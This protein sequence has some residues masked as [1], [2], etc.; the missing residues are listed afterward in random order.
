MK[1]ATWRVALLRRATH[2]VRASR[3]SREDGMPSENA[4]GSLEYG[5]APHDEISAGWSDS[6]CASW[7]RKRFKEHPLMAATPSRVAGDRNKLRVAATTLKAVERM[8][9]M[10]CSVGPSTYAVAISIVNASITSTSGSP[11]DT[12]HTLLTVT[13]RMYH[14]CRARMPRSASAAHRKKLY[15]AIMH[16]LIR[17]GQPNRCVEVYENMREDGVQLDESH[18]GLLISAMGRI[19][20]EE[21][22]W[23]LLDIAKLD[24]GVVYSPRLLACLIGAC[25][26]FS[27]ARRAVIT[28]AQNGVRIDAAAARAW[29]QACLREARIAVWGTHFK[30]LDELTADNRADLTRK[31]AAAEAYALRHGVPPDTTLA[32]SLM[33]AENVSRRFLRVVDRFNDLPGAPCLYCISVLIASCAHAV[34]RGVSAYFQAIRRQRGDPAIRRGEIVRGELPE[35][36]A[37]ALIAAVDGLAA[38]VCTGET[39]RA[40]A[41]W[42]RLAEA[43]FW[44]ALLLGT[45][46]RS[47]LLHE[48]LMGLYA[49]TG[50]RRKADL[51]LQ[52]LQK[53]EANLKLSAALQRD[54]RAARWLV[55]DPPE[56]SP[57]S[58][59]K[60]ENRPRRNDD[61]NEPKPPEARR[62]RSKRQSPSD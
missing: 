9:H 10:N 41:Y 48:C 32:A 14:E 36:T 28:F 22:A 20:D 54:W 57:E 12:E 40:A 56:L 16:S 18:Y 58:R 53:S 42:V 47:A 34:H 19:N 43:A 4:L 26:T 13:K 31:V 3:W 11:A 29:V 52:H 23:S 46:A 6:C 33:Q 27:S 55:G 49:V 50:D 21:A 7:L 24:S 45:A 15:S 60:D 51:L 35:L 38:G 8:K 61:S 44:K 59:G 17:G 25:K 30:E 62:V 2:G 5:S 39:G 37:A 1:A